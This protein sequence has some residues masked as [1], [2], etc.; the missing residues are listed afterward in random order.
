MLTTQPFAHCAELDQL[1][2]ELKTNVSDSE[3]SVSTI[4]GAVAAVS[5]LAFRGPARW[6]LLLTGAAFVQR[7]VSG[8]CPLYERLQIDPRHPRPHA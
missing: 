3:R 7:G 2:Q 4:L 1:G 8:H 6:I 5:A